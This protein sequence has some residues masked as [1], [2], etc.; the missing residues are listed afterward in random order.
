MVLP[1]INGGVF[2]VSRGIDIGSV[3]T[4]LAGE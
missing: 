4:H 2:C 3:L 1:G